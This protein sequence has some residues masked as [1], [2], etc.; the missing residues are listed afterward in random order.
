MSIIINVADG[1]RNS[2]VIYNNKKTDVLSSSSLKEGNTS[3]DKIHTYQTSNIIGEYISES[4]N[5]NLSKSQII[6]DSEKSGIKLN[7]LDDL[8]NKQKKSEKNSSFI[9]L[10]INLNSSSIS[11]GTFR[12]KEPKWTS[13][14]GF[15]SCYNSNTSDK[16]QTIRTLTENNFCDEIGIAEAEVEKCTERME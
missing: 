5:K 6:K 3:R 10:Q 7:T 8:D 2:S 11:N 4:S 9:D 1:S 15:F 14:L 16:K 13:Q 12:Q